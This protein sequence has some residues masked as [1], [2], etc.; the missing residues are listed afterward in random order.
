MALLDISVNETRI[1]QEI[2]L[3]PG[4]SRIGI[5]RNLGLNKSTVTKITAGLLE[6]RIV[7]LASSPDKME[8][9]GRRPT[10]LHLNH[11]LGVIIGIEIQ[12]DNWKAVALNLNG[13]VLDS[14]RSP[15]I[16]PQP[17][18]LPVIR[19]AMD[20]AVARQRSA[21]RVCLAM[22]IGLA[23]QVNPYES[24]ILSSNPLNIRRPLDFQAELGS[25]YP[26]P[27]FIENDANCCC[28]NVIMEKKSNRKRNFLCLLVEFR[29]TG[30][31]HEE[32]P[33]VAIGIGLVIRDSVLHGDDFSTGEFQ[34]VFKQV[35]NPS[36]FHLEPEEVSRLHLDVGL[37]TRVMHELAQNI[38]L[39]V[40]ILN[41]K[42]VKVFGDFIGDQHEVWRLFDEEIQRNW[43][44]DSTV[45]CTIEVSDQGPDAV[46]IGAAA[47]VLNRV[48]F[49][50]D[51]LEERKS[52]A[53]HGVEL[54]RKAMQ[55]GKGQGMTI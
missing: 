34:S 11:E 28:W 36:Q 30:V 5:A 40:N 2:W 31:Q 19:G 46:A 53:L 37:R 25:D 55:A 27:V 38:S 18:I 1:L 43:L 12:T 54:L 50:P 39:L 24:R 22:G 16:T 48:F 9:K 13:Q 23:G 47:Y 4:I 41:I 3:N 14:Y 10:G 49:L 32:P 17:D 35:N 42:M 6:D 33:G 29:R 44:Y 52:T 26:F 45:D 51:V 15:A 20:F 7:E 21:G 8:T